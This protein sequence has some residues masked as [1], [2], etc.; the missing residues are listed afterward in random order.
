MRLAAIIEASFLEDALG[1]HDFAR[2]CGQ[3]GGDIG[4]ETGKLLI[5]RL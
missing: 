2:E 3:R 4:F 5:E 1:I